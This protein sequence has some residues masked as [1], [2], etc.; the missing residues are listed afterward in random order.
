MFVC[1]LLEAT[2]DFDHPL[3]ISET[4]AMNLGFFNKIIHFMK[5]MNDFNQNMQMVC[6]KIPPTLG[7]IKIGTV[8]FSVFRLST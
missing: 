3:E 8:G 2:L 6:K 1:S 7:L 5:K 4:A